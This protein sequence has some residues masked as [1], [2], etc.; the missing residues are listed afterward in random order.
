MT[1][2]QFTWISFYEELSDTLL[3]YRNRRDDLINKLTSVY[4]SIG[5]SLPKLEADVH[6]MALIPSLSLASLTRASRIQTGRKSSQASPSY[7]TSEQASPRILR[8]SP[9]S[10]TSTRPAL[11]PPTTTTAASTT[12]TTSGACSRPR[13]HWPLIYKCPC[14]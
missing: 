9:C 14:G 10:T 8:A 7:S 2:T 12:S 13:L 3:T 1:S 4:E 5:M 11:P 6:C